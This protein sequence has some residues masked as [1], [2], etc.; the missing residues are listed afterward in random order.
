[1]VYL[2]SNNSITQ[3]TILH[4]MFHAWQHDHG[5]IVSGETFE[6]SY[7]NLEFETYV[8]IAVYHWSLY[9]SF[10]ISSIP[11]FPSFYTFLDECL[12]DNSGMFYGENILNY[13]HFINHVN[14]FF[15]P[16]I[17]A[18]RKK[19]DRKKDNNGLFI[20]TASELANHNYHWNWEAYFNFLGIRYSY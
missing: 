2:Y 4:E 9:G 7:Y 14:D 16:F 15:Y 17:D 12:D 3:A 11:G 10:S 5:Y 8:S 19:E 6:N 13:S 1:M 20:K 18:I